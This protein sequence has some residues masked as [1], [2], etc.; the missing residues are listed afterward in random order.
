MFALDAGGVGG[1]QVRNAV[2]IHRPL[3]SHPHEVRTQHVGV[4]PRPGEHSTEEAKPSS[5][6]WGGCHL[7]PRCLSYLA[8]HSASLHV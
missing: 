1:A 4:S 5:T 7:F 8:V 3:A 2:V 6:A